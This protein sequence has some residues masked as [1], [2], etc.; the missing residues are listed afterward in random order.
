VDVEGE[1]DYARQI[2]RAADMEF[3]ASC[4][5][6]YRAEEVMSGPIVGSGKGKRSVLF[7]ATMKVHPQTLA[8]SQDYGNC[9]SWMTREMTGTLMAIAHLLGTAQHP[10]DRPGTAVVYG[11]RGHSSQGMALSTAM[12]VIHN[13]GIQL[14]AAYC[15][16]RYDLSTERADESAG[17]SWGRSGPPGCILEA[18]HNDRVDQVSAVRDVDAA[19]D[20]LASGYPIGTGSTLTGGSGD[21]ICSLKRIGGHAQACLGYDDTDEFRD[22]YKQATG[23]TLR[24]AVFLMDQSWGNWNSLSHYPEH[25]WGPACEGLWVVTRSDF[26]KII[27]DWGNAYAIADLVGFPLREIPDWGS[28]EYL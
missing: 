23:K 28:S 9:T 5:N 21:P 17:N 6:G 8:G 18:I 16:G 7:Q 26:G 13:K 2:A 25:L 22:W 11:S 27:N 24:E 12:S 3:R 4:R 10:E 14:E 19:M 15:D 1:P 20:L